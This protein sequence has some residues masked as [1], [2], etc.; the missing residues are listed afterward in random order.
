MEIIKTVDGGTTCL[1]V[2]GR[3][4]TLTS[5]D[6][7]KELDGVFAGNVGDII[8]DFAALDYVSSAGLRVLLSTQKKVSEAGAEMK[9]T[10]ANEDIKEILDITGFT[11]FMNCE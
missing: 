6:L 9:I 5:G 2:S 3:L 11:S 8:F 7:S 4:D 10:G 1:A